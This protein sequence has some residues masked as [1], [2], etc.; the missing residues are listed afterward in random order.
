VR[1]SILPSPCPTR[2][3]GVPV[4]SSTEDSKIPTSLGYHLADIYNEELEKSMKASPE[5]PSF[6]FRP[7][8][9]LRTSLCSRHRYPSQHS[10]HYS[11][12]LA[13]YRRLLPPTVSCIPLFLLR[14]FLLD[15]N[16]LNKS[17]LLSYRSTI[18]TLPLS[19]HDDDRPRRKRAR[20]EPS[21]PPH[22]P[23]SSRMPV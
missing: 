12:D 15:S 1:L 5:V 3:I 9:Q 17:D 18:L 2:L 8:S 23:R 13:L 20:I 22:I 10:S 14:S 11:S 7:R 16:T 6:C 4:A 21:E 19:S